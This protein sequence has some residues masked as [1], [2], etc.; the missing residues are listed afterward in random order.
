MIVNTEGS[1][2]AKI[3]IVGEAPG[4]EED[5]QGKPFVGFAGH[6]LDN[7]LGQAGIARY[8]CLVT[9][10]ARER[11]PANKISYF[12]EDKKCT[13]PKPKLT[14]WIEKLKEEIELYN[15]NIIIALGTTAL[16]ALTGE[17]KI[18][19]F[20]GYILP[21]ELVKGKKVLATYHPQAVNYEWKLYFQTVLDLRKALRHSEIQS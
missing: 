16:W 10:V 20:R 13:I 1:P 14:A 11:P 18:S 17:K 4:E 3:F 19:D 12:F 2:D 8:Q 15:P 7:L 21:C 9:N 6:T 5:K